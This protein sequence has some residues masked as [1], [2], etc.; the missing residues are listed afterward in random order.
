LKLSTGL[1]FFAWVDMG[2]LRDSLLEHQRMIAIYPVF[3]R[4]QALFLDVRKLVGDQKYLGG[5]FIG[6]YKEGLTL[7][8]QEY[9]SLLQANRDR[10]LGKDQPWMF[11]TCLQNQ[12]LCLLVEPRDTYGDPGF[13]WHPTP[14]RVQV[15]YDGSHPTRSSKQSTLSI[16]AVDDTRTD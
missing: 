12:G 10:F 6:G 8:I 3:T 2:Y 4:N 7:W 16:G 15:W 11:E 1:I 13:R 5:G 14:W 9:Y